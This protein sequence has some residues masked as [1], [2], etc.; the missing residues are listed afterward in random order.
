MRLA[1]GTSACQNRVRWAAR[2]DARRRG[3][4]VRG[5]MMADVMARGVAAAGRRTAVG[6]ARGAETA[7]PSPVPAAAAKG[8]AG[9]GG[10]A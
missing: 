3:A 6:M 10:S 4:T 1:G 5:A 8:W 2:H 9:R 7:E